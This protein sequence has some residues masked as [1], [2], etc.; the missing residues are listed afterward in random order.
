MSPPAAT[1]MRP[2]LFGELLYDCFPDGSRVLGGA[3]LNVAWHLQ[4]F[5]LAPLMITAVGQDA[6]GKAALQA[7]AHWGMDTTGV[8][9]SAQYATGTV[10]IGFEEGEP[11]YMIREDSAWDHIDAACLPQLSE[12]TLLYHGSLALR[13]R[14]SRESLLALKSTLKGRRY[15]DINLRPPYWGAIQ[16]EACYL[17]G[18]VLKL[19]ADE[20]HQLSGHRSTTPAN[21]R[22]FVADHSLHQLIVTRGV[23]G[24]IA[25]DAESGT[26]VDIPATT[27]STR[28]VDTVGA[29][30]AFSS[31]CMLGLCRKWSL[32]LTLERAR[33]FASAIV[34]VR[35]ATVPDPAFYQPFVEQ[36]ELPNHV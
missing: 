21:V 1:A 16:Q 29:G 34:G 20:F 26:L 5:G 4:A 30:D 7:M 12:H 18:D 31:V 32:Q 6:D 25:H 14:A 3:P 2:V 11:H 13:Q 33:D 27:G 24:V 23:R 15:V 22:Q 9:H 8:Q 10:V 36:W 28:L 19:N 17:H 35:G